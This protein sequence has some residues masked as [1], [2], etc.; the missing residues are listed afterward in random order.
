MKFKMKFNNEIR[1][2]IGIGTVFDTG[3]LIKHTI[4][5]YRGD[6]DKGDKVLVDN[7]NS[8]WT[9]SYLFEQFY[10]GRFIYLKGADDSY[11]IPY[12]IAEKL[13]SDTASLGDEIQT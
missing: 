13:K 9:V 7:V 1:Y 12:K 10:I 11:E 4:T 6:Y 8:S 2:K 3:N 5:G